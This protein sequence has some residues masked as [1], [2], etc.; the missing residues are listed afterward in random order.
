[1][2]LGCTLALG[3]CVFLRTLL[4]QDCAPVARILPTGTATGTLDTSSCQLLDTTPY[5]PYRLDLPARG[6]LKI[7][8]SAGLT[9]LT[10]ILRDATGAQLASGTSIA[11][12]IEPGS[13]TLLVNGAKQAESGAFTLQSTFTAEPGMLC[14]NFPNLGRTQTLNN[15]LPGSG[16]VAMDGTP[17]E[18][19]T[20]T[21]DG[22]GTL[23]VNV[24]GTGFTPMVGV[25]SIDGYTVATPTENS[26][27]AVLQSGS[28]YLVVITSADQNTGAFQVTTTFQPADNETCLSQKTLAVSDSDS[29]SIGAT[30]CFITIAGSGD[31]SYYNYYN[32]TLPAGVLV[33][34][35]A[36][37]GDFNATLNLLDAAGNLV[38]SD[39]G[40]GGFDSLNNLQSNVVAQL[41]AG[42]YT[43][44]IF[45]DLPSG[46]NYSLKYAFT[47]TSPQ[48][49]AAATLNP[50]DQLTGGLNAT[51]CRTILGLTDLYTVTLPAAGTLDLEV[52]SMAFETIVAIRDAKDNLIVQDDDV[53]GLA[54]AHVTANL[55]AGVYTI[56]AASGGGA[57]A[58]HLATNFTAQAIPACT[59]AQPLNLNGGYVQRLGP[60]SCIW[61]NGQAVDYYSFTLPVDSLA[62]A[63]MTSSEVDG[64]LTLYDSNGNVLRM[65][66]NSYGS[67]DPLIVQYLPA[68]SYK[69]AARGA[70]ATVGGL[71]EVDL[72]TAAGPRVPFCTP[73][74]TVALTGSVTGTIGYTGC[75]YPDSTFAD[76][77][78]VTL[79]TS[80]T[81]DVRLN[82]SAF[83]AYLVL[84][85]SKGALVTQDDDSGGGTNARIT[86]PL[87]AGN[88]YIVAKP[89]GD[90]TSA[91]AYTLIT[92]TTTGN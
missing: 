10:L 51:S 14:A 68:G 81:L 12:P 65:D 36:G 34:A 42:N 76:I 78:Q 32:L 74:A 89:F 30:S 44:Q 11:T 41:P 15:N 13:Y 79:T 73:K 16:C 27:N 28:Q 75:Q 70:S 63:V 26:L 61:T 66:D 40:S 25:R 56:A 3:C 59:F 53:N 47:P 85:D 58:Y 38:A 9:D 22:T 88:Y 2:T 54:I 4:A 31:E 48:P 82:S 84:L 92:A 72:R 18:A 43:L 86:A 20:V 39:S 5:N 45:S 17:Y 90:Y 80:G 37:S 24:A 64:Y 19:Y 23:T 7:Q 46:G 50:G 71:Y 55:P 62:L 87:A 1:M 67:N 6:Q 91:G 21:T 52:D 29:N 49:C 60:N 83:D 57:G 33:N 69:L 8:V 77:Y 35:S